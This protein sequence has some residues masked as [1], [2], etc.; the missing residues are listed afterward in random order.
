MAGIH[1]LESVLKSPVHKQPWQHQ[2][3]N[4]AIPSEIF[5][6]LKSQCEQF[7]NLDTEGNLK[8]IFP[9]EFDHYGITLYDSIYDIGKTILDHA[10]DL[11]KGLYSNP[12]SY[13]SLTVYTHIS[14][15]PPLPFQFEIHEEGL[16]KIWS[17]VTYVTP[18][19]NIGT[20][21]YKTQSPDSF[22]KESPWHPNT[23]FI[24]CGQKGKTW[25]SYESSQLTNRITLNYFLMSDK[26]GKKFI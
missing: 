15:T 18:Q 16:E 23:T 6:Q 13:P 21:M 22:V 2:V 25:H 4:N 7:L 3:V 5:D 12:R 11:T 19:N 8:F 10:D 20:K 24:F 1:F 17:S 9:Y 26:R 14:I